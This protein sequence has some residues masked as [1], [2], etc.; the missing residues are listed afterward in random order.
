[1]NNSS[2]DPSPLNP[3]AQELNDSI[4]SIAPTVYDLLSKKGREIYYPSKGII[5]QSAEAKEQADPAYNATVGIATD[6]KGP[7]SF[8]SIA[9]YFNTE[10]ISPKEIFDYSPTY[11]QAKLRK[12]WQEHIREVNPNVKDQAISM[13]VVG[14]GL[15]HCLSVTG[16]MFFDANDTLILPDQIWG[17]YRL[18]YTTLHGVTIKQF[19]FLNSDGFNLEGF[20]TIL[21]EEAQAKGEV[22]LILNFPNNPTGYTPTKK[23]VQAITETFLELANQGTKVLVILDEAY[24]GLFFGDEVQQESLFGNLCN[25]HEN[26]VT[27]KICGATKEFF[28]WGF[29]VG[30]IT[31]GT[32]GAEHEKVEQ[33]YQALEKKLG[34]TV[35]ATVSNCSSVAQNILIKVLEDKSYLQDFKN[36]FNILE[37]RAKCIKEILSD[38]RYEDVFTPYPFNSGYFMLIRLRGVESE[39]LRKVLLTKEKI[40]TISTA[41]HDLRIAFS[42]LETKD[43][44]HV[45]EKIYQTAK[46]L[47]Q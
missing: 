43:I 37:E 1:M 32:K 11:G 4:K 33:L 27:V 22:R 7:L 3:L 24:Y 34:G 36:N 26:I 40:G 31:I 18:F 28:V 17:N 41:K 12:L 38:G 19:P 5:A 16:Q 10:L 25:A 20:K 23:E 2:A 45:F 13:P 42:C 15:T 30:F 44:A 8:P 46:T 21:K 39:V 14:G 9:K 29:R 47:M 6:S 35:R